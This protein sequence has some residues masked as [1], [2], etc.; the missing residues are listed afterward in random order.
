MKKI[1]TLTRR[2]IFDVL[3]NGLES[4][5]IFDTSRQKFYIGGILSLKDFL[6]RLYPLD[7]MIAHDSRLNN[8]NCLYGWI[9]KDERFRLQNG[10]DEVLLNFLCEIFHP[11]VRDDSSIWKL[12]LEKIN[13][14]I[15]NDGY[16][17]YIN[18]VI[19]GRV[20]YS[21]RK[22][23]SSFSRVKKEDVKNFMTLFCR[24]GYVLDFN[25]K[26]FNQFTKDIIGIP[27]NEYYGLSKGRSLIKFTEEWNENDVIK[28]CIALFDYYDNNKN[29][30]KEKTSSE[31][32][33][34]YRKCV[35]SVSRLK[36]SVTL[37]TEIVE[38]LKIRFS[39]EY[40][41]SQL[42]LMKIMQSENPTEAIGKAK[43]L[44]ESCCKT[45]LEDNNITINKKWNLVQLVDTTVKYLKVTPKDVS[46][47]LPEADCIKSILHNLKLIAINI[48][49]LR[50]SYG[51]GHGKSASYKGLE[52]R[53]AKLAVGSATVLVDFLW[54]THERKHRV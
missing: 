32:K 50:N 26:T 27:L 4:V 6:G 53:H 46:D 35:E 30:E 5:N 12:V 28:L 20:V 9:F 8:E 41:N 17:F 45:I 24:D 18:G 29:Y 49:N 40:M 34:I 14:F 37:V 42:D 25:N 52:E 11:E 43:E 51:S 22:I 33:I 54:N 1:T 16:E 36:A 19:S 10:E 39:S 2:D 21:W 47:S 44:I 38:N 7:E 13:Q 23:K 15:S 48:S 3:T 31:Y